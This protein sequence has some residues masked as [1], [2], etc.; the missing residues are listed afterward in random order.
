MS[1]LLK[2]WS[3]VDK[4]NFILIPIL[5][6]V[7]I[8]IINSSDLIYLDNRT[9]PFIFVGTGLFS[10]IWIIY[11]LIKNILEAPYI[12]SNRTSCFISITSFSFLFL[13]KIRR[14]SFFIIFD[15]LI[16]YKS[17]FIFCSLN[18]GSKKIKLKVISNSFLLSFLNTFSVLISVFFISFSE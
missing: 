12:F 16:K 8:L 15:S 4:I 3:S 5:A 14:P 6:F 18:G 11:N 9:K 10:L 2:W 7:F 17:I 13:C 1:H